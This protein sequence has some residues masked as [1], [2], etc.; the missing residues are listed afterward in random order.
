MILIVRSF[1]TLYLTGIRLSLSLRI[2]TRRS[3][4][5]VTR[6]MHGIL[7]AARGV[8]PKVELI[9]SIGTWRGG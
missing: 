9:I 5:V 8:V 6:A 4:V 2:S 3:Q 7:L 1:E